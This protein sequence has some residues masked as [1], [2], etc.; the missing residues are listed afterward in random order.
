MTQR[1]PLSYAQNMEDFHLSLA[2]A[3]QQRGTYIDIGGGHPVAG[4]VSFWFYK[5]GW[6][7]IVVE[8]QTDLARLH[9]QL[10]PR[11]KVMQL[12]VGADDKER[13]FHVFDRL[14][15]LS[16]T[17]VEHA[18]AAGA[19][20]RTLRLPS[21]SLAELC[22][23][24]AP[25]AIDFLKIDVEGAEADVIAG[26][27]WDRFR[28]GIVL[29]ESIAPLSNE[30]TWDKWEAMLLDKGYRFALFDTLNRFYVA[31]ERKDLLATMPTE[32]APWDAV[33][34]MYEIGRAPD[35][36]VHPDHELA[37]DL[38]RGFWASLPFLEDEV[39]AA[40]LRRGRELNGREAGISEI[41]VSSG[42]LRAS[43]GLIAS[44]Y[45]GGFVDDQASS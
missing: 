15:G 33:L 36:E 30:P 16:T 44:A 18:K 31:E 23:T 24:H 20:F 10:R 6:D 29:V 25:D 2:F 5:R 19:D 12:L 17:V 40:I 34:H 41:E 39:L 28:P 11:D 45:D 38:E 43:L 37:K 8:P 14:H 26:A 32:R 3:D 22:R 21:I 27:D 4:S 7:G 9:R 35:S 42:A 1:R 13:D